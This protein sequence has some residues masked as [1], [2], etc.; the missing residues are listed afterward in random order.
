MRQIYQ[1]PEQPSAMGRLAGIGSTALGLMTGGAGLLLI[2]GGVAAAAGN[3]NQGANT[4]GGIAGAA[5]TGIDIK[6]SVPSGAKEDTRDFSTFFGPSKTSPQGGGAESSMTR[7]KDAIEA[8]S[9]P[10]KMIT[11]PTNEEIAHTFRKAEIELNE[12]RKTNPELAK[13]YTEPLF[14][15]MLQFAPYYRNNIPINASGKFNNY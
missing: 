14:Q 5:K 2:P 12:L 6:S 4:L 11:P 1:A 7:A 10:P 15:G 3:Q 9:N 13:Q 8:S